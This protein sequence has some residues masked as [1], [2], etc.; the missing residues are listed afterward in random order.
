MTKAMFAVTFLLAAAPALGASDLGIDPEIAS[1][2]A[3]LKAVDN[4][5]HVNSTDP[6]DGD[7]DALPLDSLPDFDLPARF[8]PNSPDRLAAYR[9]VYGY[10]HDDLSDAHQAELQATMEKVA[11]EQGD[12]F[13]EWALGRI[14]TEVMF[15][16]RV[17][18]GPGLK[19]PHFQWVSYV[20]ALMLPLSSKSVANT[21]DR[22]KL[23]P[24]E[25]KLLH[26][27]LDDLHLKQLPATLDAYVK[28]VVTPTLESQRK[29]G[30]IAVK[31]E[32]AY[33]RSLA[34][35]DASQSA[36]AKVYARYV[37]GGTPPAAEYKSLQDYLF[38]SIAREAGRLG[39]AVHIHAIE[40][41]GGYYVAADSDPLLLE[42]AFNDPSLRRTNFVIIHG[43]G[44][45]A[46][47]ANA[48]AWKPNVYL[49]LS[50]MPLIYG[51]T[52]LGTILRDWLTQWPQKVLFG[53]DAFGLG[54][55]FGWEL[56]AWISQNTAR[57]AL[58]IALTDMMRDGLIDRDRAKEIATMVLR[59]NAAKLYGLALK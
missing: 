31:F 11:K 4:H 30:C 20:D 12:N 32:A 38:R 55:M 44:M 27:Y 46:A 36:A 24:L 41:A 26:R 52:Q 5:S 25:E 19:P 43:G 56:T 45:Y 54:P 3:G 51:P 15:G 58:G 10:K 28:T 48:M 6:Q 42:P 7:S 47:H 40:G 14:G 33:L 50:V 23:Y 35:N 34:F 2:I 57:Q 39:M 13:P 53:T 21:P 29:R 8:S 22:E 1:F 37:R 59:G 17:A 49:D 16:N 18:M 9:A